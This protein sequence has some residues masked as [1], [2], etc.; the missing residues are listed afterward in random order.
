MNY[1]LNP[2]FKTF[3][4]VKLALSTLTLYNKV[5]IDHNAKDH[6]LDLINKKHL[7]IVSSVPII[8]K[9]NNVGNSMIQYCHP[10]DT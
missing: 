7:L 5:H 3:L 4:K 1:N 10:L 6:T 2:A 8:I 9:W